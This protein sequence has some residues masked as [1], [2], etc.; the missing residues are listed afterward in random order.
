M[1]GRRVLAILALAGAIGLIVP[2]E[3]WA[4]VSAD[5]F[6]TGAAT[7]TT[8]TATARNVAPVSNSGLAYSLYWESANGQTSNYGSD[9]NTFDPSRLARSLV[10]IDNYQSL[11]AVLTVS[12]SSSAPR[13]LEGVFRLPL[14]GYT[15]THDNEALLRATA[16]TLTSTDA[17][18][19]VT[20]ALLSQ[21]ASEATATPVPL[22]GAASAYAAAGGD[23]GSLDRILLAGSI[24]PGETVRIEI[25]LAL[26][27]DSDAILW[28]AQWSSISYVRPNSN[29]YGTLPISSEIRFARQ[30][31]HVDADGA[32]RGLLDSTGRYFLG[33]RSD[34]G[35]YNY[36]QAPE[37]IQASAPRISLGDLAVN[38]IVGS[39]RH[40]ATVDDVVYSG[41]RYYINL[42]RIKAAVRDLGWSVA[43][44]SSVEI[45][46]DPADDLYSEYTYGTYG[47]PFL[48]ANDAS[49]TR[50]HL[51]STDLNGV[52]I[53]TLFTEVR[54]VIET[55][56]LE[57]SVGDSWS[58]ADSLVSMVDH[59]G[60]RV[61]PDDAAHVRVV[62]DVD[63][64]RP[65]TY[66][67]R[68]YYYHGGDAASAGDDYEASRT[69]TV[70]VKGGA[71]SGQT[72]R[73]DG[74]ESASGS[75]KPD[76]PGAA[77]RRRRRAALPK[78]GDAALLAAS[79]AAASGAALA[80]AAWFHRRR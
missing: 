42:D 17:S 21:G 69:A 79:A 31:T 50:L 12:N 60:D 33:V 57:L 25:P 47:A 24:A 38:N 11:K 66:S 8:G 37:E 64:T 1:R 58:A 71:D 2:G 41:A 7:T 26:A 68:F 6:Y 63:T 44:G 45:D 5:S 53:G 75:E 54:N 28:G 22:S 61:S 70:T 15:G 10:D 20:A 74:R 62:S 59:A 3:A 30:M 13:R 77:P 48:R 49:G 65:G 55:R 46:P 56:D 80:G 36:V 4:K 43:A 14:Y 32:A 72:G 73:T 40:E 16:S 76:G 51:N 18:T 52:D 23:M 67:V 9:G 39:D 27:N 34:E 29:T 19:G 78:T 35:S